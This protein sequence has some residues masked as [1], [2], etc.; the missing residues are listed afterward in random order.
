MSHLILLY[1]VG[2][3]IWNWKHKQESACC[4][5]LNQ[6]VFLFSVD[7]LIFPL[8]IH[9]Y[10]S[11]PTTCRIFVFLRIY[12][13]TLF[14]SRKFIK[15]SA[16]MWRFWKSCLFGKEKILKGWCDRFQQT[17]IYY[18]E[19]YSLSRIWQSKMVMVVFKHTGD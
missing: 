1:F 3:S 11:N 19:R 16:V 9:L 10:F 5:E 13:W 4:L 2:L 12:I 17:E 7:K 6:K 15:I 14:L 8:E 18:I